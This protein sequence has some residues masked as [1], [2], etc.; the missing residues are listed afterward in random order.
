MMKP[1]TPGPSVRMRL[2]AAALALALG[3]GGGLAAADEGLTTRSGVVPMVEDGRLIGC[4][5]PFQVVR[6]DP[7]YSGGRRVLVEGLMAVIMP[8]G[9]SPGVML[10]MVVH[11]PDDA[12]GAAGKAPDVA[13]P[14]DGGKTGLEERYRKEGADGADDSGLFIY[15]LGPVTEA[16]LRGAANDGRFSLVY[17]LK[18]GGALAPLTVDLTVKRR[19]FGGAG[20]RDPGAPQAFAECLRRLRLDNLTR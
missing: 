5:A 2:A 20:E 16:A 7:E 3:M 6:A 11:G 15:T 14:A 8:P 4:Q 9:S 17:A 12:E 13:A 1:E 10:R 19:A 18:A